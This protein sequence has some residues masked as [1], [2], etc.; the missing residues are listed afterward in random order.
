MSENRKNNH[1]TGDGDIARVFTCKPYGREFT[2]IHTM[3]LT[4]SCMK[5]SP[6]GGKYSVAR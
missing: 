6:R 1:K 5:N 3:V 4:N 2:A